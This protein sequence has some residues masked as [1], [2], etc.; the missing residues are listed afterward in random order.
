MKRRIVNAVQC[1]E[2]IAVRLCM[3][4]CMFVFLQDNSKMGSKPWSPN[5]AFTETFSYPGIGVSLGS[6]GQRSHEARTWV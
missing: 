2:G 3:S 5:L 4:V 6:N 1:K